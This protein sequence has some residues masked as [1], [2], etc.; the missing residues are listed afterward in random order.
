MRKSV[1]GLLISRRLVVAVV[2]SVALLAVGCSSSKSSGSSTGTSSSTSS[3]VSGLGTPKPATGSPLRVGFITNGQNGSIDNLS[4]IPAAQAA[5]KY[6][7]NYLGGA[8]GHVLSLDICNNMGT[9]SG[10]TNCANQLIAAKVPVVLNNVD[11]ENQTTYADLNKAGVP[12][13][14]Y[15]TAVAAQLTGTLSYVLSNGLASSF[16]GPAKIAQNVGAK[17]AALFVID[18]PAASGPAKQLEPIIYKNAGIPVD[19]VAVAPGTADMT[20]QVQAELSKG[21]DFIEVLGDVS[22][23]TSALKATKT[24]GF[25]GTTV[26]IAQCLASGSSSGIPG[27]YA[28]MKVVTVATTDPSDPDVMTYEAAMK[29]Y[30]PGTAPF[31]TGVT[32]GAFATVVSFARAMTGLSGTT[33]ADIESTLTSMAPQ[34]LFFGAGITF[35]CNGKQIAITPAVCSTGAL[36]V[37]LDANGNPAGAFTPLETSALLKL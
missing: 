30:A 25:S 27:G 13:V 2:L 23:C 15:Q 33:S 32:S 9:P 14:A 5:V 35:Q 11:A 19:V 18:V 26:L 16:A 24:L 37:T 10:A 17:R 36:E 4:E 3:S 20:P 1:R 6:V 7:N 28:G 29:A 22:F 8:G 21:V 31:S 34:P 12:Y